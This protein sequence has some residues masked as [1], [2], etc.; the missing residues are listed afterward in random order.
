MSHIQEYQTVIP[1]EPVI[2]ELSQDEKPGLRLPTLTVPKTEPSAVFSH[3]ELR[4]SE[5]CLPQLS[6]PE[7][8]RHFTR[9]S[10]QN[11]NIDASIYPLGSCTMKYN[12]RI[13][14]DLARMPEV[15]LMHP[16]MPEQLCQGHLQMIYE[17]EQD[18]GEI[19]GLPA[20]S[21]QPA[22]GAQGEF[23]ALKVAAAYFASRGEAERTVV[24][25]PDS[26]HGTNP[27]SAA[28]CGFSLVEIPTGKDGIVSVEALKDFLNGRLAVVMMTNPN[29]LGRFESNIEDIARAVHKAGG[30]VYCDGANLN[31]ILGY[32]RPG[33]FGVD[34]MHINLHKTFST[35]HGGGGPGAGPICCR[36][37]LEPF[38]PT[39]RV[40]KK[41]DRFYT[42]VE[43]DPK[44]TVGKVKSFYGNYGVLVRAWT[45]IRMIGPEG[46]RE[47]AKNAVLSANYIKA[48]LKDLY[49]ETFEGPTLHEAVLCD[50]KIK[51]HGITTAELAKMLLDYGVHPPTVYFPLIVSGAL[52]IE[53][54]ETENLEELDRFIFAMRDSFERAARGETKGQTFPTKTP[55]T[56]ID[57]TAAA[58][59]PTLT[60]QASQRA[61]K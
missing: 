55:R 41:G 52:M 2:F 32:A 48:K 38:L 40:Q 46:L 50:K 42:W 27:A 8:V 23:S 36:A 17:L 60:W 11:Y 7:V 3:S 20:V 21:L 49:P 43:Q 26:A 15:A 39:P 14:E 58:R 22:A 54:T 25:T 30:L 24:V 16:M 12:P 57:E 37:D 56:K 61:E 59:K 44:K 10:M 28:L 35:P 5:P 4:S 29:T 47:T 1:A 9:L 34:I 53:P 45:Y 51:E 13:N 31:A 19:S 6:E 33:D 18:L